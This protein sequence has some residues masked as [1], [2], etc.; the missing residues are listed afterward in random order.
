MGIIYQ[1]K[2][3]CLKV[4]DTSKVD[5]IPLQYRRNKKWKARLQRYY[6]IS[7]ENI[8]S[9]L[10]VYKHYPN[11]K[12]GHLI[13]NIP[14]PDGTNVIAFGNNAC[15]RYGCAN[16][17]NI[18]FFDKNKKEIEKKQIGTKEERNNFMVICPGQT[19]SI[20]YEINDD[21]LYTGYYRRIHSF[22]F[23]SI[24]DDCGPCSSPEQ[25]PSISG[26]SESEESDSDEP[27]LYSISSQ[28]PDEDRFNPVTN[29]EIQEKPDEISCQIL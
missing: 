20:N 27:P 2:I 24:C 16:I 6:A 12:G 1:C 23:N 14:V 21:E 26:E 15:D 13:V 10:A 5:L 29:F 4:K 11:S 18:T 9:V 3:R 7:K 17:Y 22:D 8:E 28:S 19:R 25:S